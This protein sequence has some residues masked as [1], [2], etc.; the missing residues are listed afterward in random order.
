[1]CVGIWKKLE[2]W[3]TNFKT[4][5]IATSAW[6]CSIQWRLTS[7]DD[8]HSKRRMV[9]FK[10]FL[11]IAFATAK[12]TKSVNGSKMSSAVKTRCLW[13]CDSEFVN[14]LYEFTSSKS[15]CMTIRS[16]IKLITNV[17]CLALCGS[18]LDRKLNAQTRTMTSSFS[19][20]KCNTHIWPITNFNC[21]TKAK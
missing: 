15:R 10:N 19:R 7:F 20:L 11:T 3:E 16:R 17:W 13:R 4:T 1:M 5:E 21:K 12:P 18:S 2:V 14:C 8:T 6:V 9:Q